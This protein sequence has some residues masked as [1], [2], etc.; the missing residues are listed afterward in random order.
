MTTATPM[1][2]PATNAPRT[3]WVAIAREL[4]PAFASRAPAL[5]ANDSFP[6]D[7]YRELQEQKAFSAAVPAVLGGGD[8]SPA[9]LSAMLRELGRHCGATALALS[10]HTHLTMGLV[11]LWRQG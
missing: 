5:D 7:N 3:D 6:F 4:G 11:W 2:S 9:E 8:A 1:S 10:M